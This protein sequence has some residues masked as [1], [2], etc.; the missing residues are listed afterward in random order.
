MRSLNRVMMIGNLAADP[1]LRQTKSGHSLSTFA[2]A[3]SRTVLD[4]NGDKKEITDFH[5]VVAW[6]KLAEICSQYLVKGMA[7]FIE[8][9][10][11]NRSFDDK[12]GHRHYR[13]EV[14][15]E[16]LNILTWRKSKTG[17]NLEVENIA[18]GED[19]AHEP[20]EKEDLVA[21]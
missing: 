11:M 10:L 18:K 5:R 21:A 13:T 14:S 19:V 17:G 4:E 12:E 8:G 20:V 15:L 2:V 6:A 1:E 7:V 9:R 16:D 3:T